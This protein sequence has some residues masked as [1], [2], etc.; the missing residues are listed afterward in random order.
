MSMTAGE[1]RA[2]IDALGLTI[3]DVARMVGVHDRSARN[4]LSGKHAVPGSV[5]ATVRRWESETVAIED[6]EI[7]AAKG[8]GV[9]TVWASDGEF[10][11]AR[12]DLAAWPAK[13][14]R[15]VAVNVADELGVPIAFEGE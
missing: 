13:W 9:V 1:F 12:P 8:A 15:L 6:A 3:S 11:A 2:R 10:H 14:W 5:A 4:W 7:D